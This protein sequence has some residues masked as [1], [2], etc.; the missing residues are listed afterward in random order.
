MMTNAQYLLDKLGEE[1]VEVTQMCS[2]LKQFGIDEKQ[3]ED[4]P[5]NRERLFGELNDLF[6]A[7]QMLNDEEGLGFIPDVESIN[8]KIA[9]VTH[10][11]E[12]SRELGLVEKEKQ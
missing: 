5:T 8:R 10:Y 12:Y 2:K 3:F 11:R 6:A 1:C 7:I 9:K 4:G